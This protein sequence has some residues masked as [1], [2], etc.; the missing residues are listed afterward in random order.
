MMMHR[1]TLALAPWLLMAAIPAGNLVASCAAVESRAPVVTNDV[2]AAEVA[3]T[4]AERVALIYTGLPRCLVVGSALM[5]VTVGSPKIC[6]SQTAVDRIK[7]LDQQAY[8]AVMAAKRN[9]GL[10]SAAWS[11]ISV[12]QSAIPAK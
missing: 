7:A 2:A 9:A 11:A 6:S 3:L 4:A 5:P 8:D 12:F 1:Y 10:I